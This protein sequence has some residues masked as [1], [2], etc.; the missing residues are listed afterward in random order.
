[1]SAQKRLTSRT[2]SAVQG[3]A[4]QLRERVAIPREVRVPAR[5]PVAQPVRAGVRHALRPAR[6]VEGRVCLLVDPKAAA[7]AGVERAAWGVLGRAVTGLTHRPLV[8]QSLRRHGGG[9]CIFQSF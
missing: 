6:A 9:R 2:E 4:G 1:M 5:H 7:V 3:V 8:N